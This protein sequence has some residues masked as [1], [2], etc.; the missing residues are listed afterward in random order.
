VLFSF[1]W[2][3]LVT[4]EEH[5]ST[6]ARGCRILMLDTNT[7]NK[8]TSLPRLIP[9]LRYV[10]LLQECTMIY[11]RSFRPWK[12]TIAWTKLTFSYPNSTAKK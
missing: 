9:S 5:R 11:R 6:A 7:V 3:G 2:D 4:E 12:A 8:R 1:S 10:T